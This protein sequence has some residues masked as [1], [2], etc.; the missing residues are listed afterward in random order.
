MVVGV[1]VVAEMMLLQVLVLLVCLG[2]L[3]LAMVVAEMML[4]QV[5]ALLVWSGLLLLVMVV[6]VVVVAEM[7]LLQVLALLGGGAGSQPSGVEG[8]CERGRANAELE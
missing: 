2:L 8:V 1:V 7:M 4:L 3:L 6:V 5:L